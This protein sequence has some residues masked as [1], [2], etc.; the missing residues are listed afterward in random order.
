VKNE[1]QKIAACRTMTYS[2]GMSLIHVSSKCVNHLKYYVFVYLKPLLW[3]IFI[4]Q[5]F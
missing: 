4:V 5:S 2:F 3:L 1:I